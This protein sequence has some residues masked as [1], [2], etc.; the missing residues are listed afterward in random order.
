MIDYPHTHNLRLLTDLCQANGIQVPTEFF[1]VDIFNRYAVQW[2]YDLLPSLPE[3]TL[4]RKDAY[5][6]AER[7]WTWANTSVNQE[8]G[9][10]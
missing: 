9:L 4:D 1:E 2:R 8:S 6:L 10:G 5:D 7:I 3:I